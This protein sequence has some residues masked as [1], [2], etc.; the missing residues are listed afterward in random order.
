MFSL[1]KGA[2]F[3]TIAVMHT[4]DRPFSVWSIKSSYTGF[5]AMDLQCLQDLMPEIIVQLCDL[6]WDNWG[7]HQYRS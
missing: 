6:S 4:V 5:D 2:V 1:F 3:L 7:E